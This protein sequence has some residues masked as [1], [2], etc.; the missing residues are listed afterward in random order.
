MIRN[1]RCRCVIWA[2]TCGL[3]AI[4]FTGGLAAQEGDADVSARKKAAD[5]IAEHKYDEA[6]DVLESL[7]AAH[8]DDKR[9]LFDC[10]ATLAWSERY[11]EAADLSKDFLTIN[12]PMYALAAAAQAQRNVGNL[13]Q[14][15]ALYVDGEKRYPEASDFMTGHI[16]TLADAGRFDEAEAR[17]KTFRER[18]GSTRGIADAESYVRR[19]RADY[20]FN[21]RR[22]AAVVKARAGKYDEAL[23]ELGTL[24]SERPGTDAIDF[25]MITILSW[26]G[27]YAESAR[28]ADSVDL[29]KAPAYAREAAAV[30]YRES[31]QL[32]KAEALYRALLGKDRKN[33]DLI[34]GLAMTLAGQGRPD[35]AR[36][37]VEKA[38]P[39]R[40]TARIAI[41]NAIVSD[42]RTEAAKLARAGKYST[43]IGILADLRKR[44]PDASDLIYDDLTILSWAG[45]YGEATALAPRVDMSAAPDYAL[46]A[47][48]G[49]YRK[50][51][52]LREAQ[53]VYES[54]RR[55]FPADTDLAAGMAMTMGD[56]GDARGGMTVLDDFAAN[57]PGIDQKEIEDARRYL[58]QPPPY[59][60]PPRPD[61]S[62]RK[63]QDALLAM[64]KTGNLEKALMGMSD[65]FRANSADQYLL[66]D[67][68]VLLNWSREH[69]A[70][71][72]LAPRLNPAL[73]RSDVAAAAAKSMFALQ[74]YFEGEKFLD[75]AVAAQPGNVELMV[76]AAVAM[77]KAGLVA[78]AGAYFDAAARSRQAGA[79]NLVRR[80]LKECHYETVLY[81][82]APDP[83]GADYVLKVRG[84]DGGRPAHL[85]RAAMDEPPYPGLPPVEAW[86]AKLEA[87]RR[88]AG[89]GEQ[90]ELPRDA[91]DR[92]RHLLDALNAMDRLRDEPECLAS[93]ECRVLAGAVKVKAFFE[94]G[95]FCEAIT[96]YESIRD[97]GVRIPD[98]P[99]LAAAGSYLG[100]RRPARA[101]ILY[102]EFLARG[103]DPEPPS[104][105]DAYAARDGLFWSLLEN[106]ELAAA[107]AAADLHYREGTGEGVDRALYLDEEYYKTDV[108][109]TLGLAYLYTGFLAKAERTLKRLAA[110]AP[111]NVDALSALATAHSM[112][113]QP[114][115][116]NAAARR[117]LNLSPA[118]IGLT[119]Q[120]GDSF[121]GYRDW[122]NAERMV[123]AVRPYASNDETVR[124]LQRDWDIHNR[125]EFRLDLGWSNTFKGR[126]PGVSGPG[127]YPAI[128]ARLF[129]RPIAHDWRVFIGGATGGG[130]FE[131]GS[132]WQELVLGGV[133]YRGPFAA[134]TLELR[135]DHM[136][137]TE[138]GMELSGEVTPDDHWSIPFS[139][140]LCSRQTPL[141][142]RYNGITA[143]LLGSGVSYAWNESRSFRSTVTGMK[144]SD[145]NRRLELYG[146]YN[147]RLWT[148]FNHYLDG[149]LNASAGWNSLDANRPYFNPKSEREIGVGLTYGNILWR[150]YDRSL[151]HAVTVGA[152]SHHQKAH[153]TNPVWNAEYSQTLELT[154]GFSVTYGAGYSSDMYDGNRAQSV[155]G[156]LSMVLRF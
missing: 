20:E 146:E 118:D 15:I 94:M 62:Y 101:K 82:R 85:A 22:D 23:A 10:V 47:L 105:D 49:S 75:G 52:R 142:A 122:R 43:A 123:D 63:E 108:G 95:M 38:L 134:A 79:L 6:A 102:L 112:R 5:L 141:R 90:S 83:A 59:T 1:Q 149:Q 109:T 148:Y 71:S 54:G 140:E 147:H 116:A 93:R 143:N 13:D 117:A 21:R 97:A 33:V 99:L 2:L 107:L 41:E 151:S 155:N 25:D 58:N 88:S 96:E 29:G 7:H 91:N 138:F 69:T 30:S 98:G 65:L 46:V 9:I 19:C 127:D 84:M 74:L 114:R 145:G 26:A 121:L 53:A 60:P 73:A 153:G 128:E 16:L 61:A 11:R 78:P 103:R 119:A 154:P 56:L 133:E 150:R 89:W 137:N 8:P 27:R 14:A 124:R 67:Y 152:G 92:S 129:S 42:R 31:G 87:G 51:N 130:K 139:F 115:A 55:R 39:G 81:P 24:K 77:A 86:R 35:E 131:E 72:K 12:P 3:F 37:L 44:Y 125:R 17:I 104:R 110:D 48:A 4:G 120:M 32:P 45:R 136:R 156:F 36:G 80:G 57:H 40:R 106:E 76:E 70:V 28:L 50:Q 66:G 18:Y 135:G 111:G 126:D 34:Q 113:E 64:G 144:F 100:A 132:A 68:I